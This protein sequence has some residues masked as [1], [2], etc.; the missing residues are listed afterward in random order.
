MDWHDLVFSIGGIVFALA[1]LPSLFGTHKPEFITSCLT[2]TVLS[3][4]SL[5]YF[6]LDFEYSGTITAITSLMWLSLAWQV[7]KQEGF[8]K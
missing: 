5:T 1:L 4:F 8:L 2:S 6:D 7:G 3:M